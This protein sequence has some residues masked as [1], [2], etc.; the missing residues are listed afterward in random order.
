LGIKLKETVMAK[1]EILFQNFPEETEKNH[2]NSSQVVMS[3]DQ[4]LNTRLYEY[5]AVLLIT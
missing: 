2:G 4:D 5:L 3:V 1:Y